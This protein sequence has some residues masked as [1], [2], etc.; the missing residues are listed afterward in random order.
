MLD[1]AVLFGYPAV[2]V[3]VA[4]VVFV[5]VAVVLA[6]DGGLYLLLHSNSKRR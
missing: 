4:V 5:V 2:A 3:A 1:S 6:A